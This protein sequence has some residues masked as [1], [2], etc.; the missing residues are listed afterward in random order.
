MFII[1]ASFLSIYLAA[2][3]VVAAPTHSRRSTASQ[4][5]LD[6]ASYPVLVDIQ[7]SASDVC[8]DQISAPVSAI[9]FPESHGEGVQDGDTIRLEVDQKSLKAAKTD[10][11]CGSAFRPKKCH[12]EGVPNPVMIVFKKEDGGFW[13]ISCER[14]DSEEQPAEDNSDNTEKSEPSAAED[15]SKDIE[16]Q[17]KEKNSNKSISVNEFDIEVI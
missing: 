16:K 8:G 3:G 6:D 14:Q 10:D 5:S 11:S 2:Y 12:E 17:I 4:N 7:F 9:T 15:K 1:S 13:Q